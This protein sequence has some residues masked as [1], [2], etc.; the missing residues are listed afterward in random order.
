MKTLTELKKN[1]SEVTDN[2]LEGNFDLY[3]YCHEQADSDSRVIYYYQAREYVLNHPDQSELEDEWKELGFEFKDLDT[4]LTQLAF[5]GVKNEFEFNCIEDI[6]KDLE[7][8]N[9]TLIDNQVE[10]DCLE[11]DS[12]LEARYTA[13]QEEIENAIAEIEEYV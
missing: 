2:I 8:L 3:D 12:P 6:K 7:L 13:I 9:D 1:T 11:I 4:L 10:L 5:I